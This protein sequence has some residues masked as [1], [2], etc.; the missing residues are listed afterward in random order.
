MPKSAL[1]L[2]C[3]VALIALALVAYPAPGASAA[4]P[5]KRRSAGSPWERPATVVVVLDQAMPEHRFQLARE[6]IR[7]LVEVL[8]PDEWL[9]IIAATGSL[10]SQSGSFKLDAGGRARVLSWLD[11]I[12]ASSDTNPLGLGPTLQMA[13]GLVEK[14]SAG[15]RS[16]HI[17]LVSDGSHVA[18]AL[19]NAELREIVKGLARKGVRVDAL[20]PGPPPVRPPLEA[21]A[22]LGGGRLVIVRSA[23]AVEE[24]LAR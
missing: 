13:E 1:V 24:L 12:A 7:T 14:T 15:M 10:I 17:V 9:G 5:A 8:G 18:G 23:S 3:A 11:A 16:S 19:S 22:E 2:G 20:S 4:T 21:L 6:S